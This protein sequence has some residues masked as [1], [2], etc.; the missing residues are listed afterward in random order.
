MHSLWD[1]KP[2]ERLKKRS[3]VISFTFL[4]VEVSS[5]VL[6]VLKAMDR[7]NRKI[8]KEKTAV[9]KA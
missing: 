1:W 4:Q 6:N 9:V 5:T 2:V 8:R 3:H 7:G